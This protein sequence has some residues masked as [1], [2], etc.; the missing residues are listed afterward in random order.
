LKRNPPI[1][2]RLTGAIPWV[3]RVVQKHGMTVNKANIIP[4]LRYRDATK[5]IEWLCDAFGFEQQVVVPGP[6]GTIAHAQLTL[7]NGM[8]MLGSVTP[9]DYGKLVKQPDETGGAV[10]QSTYV[11]I[12][13]ADA[14]YK[15]AKAAGAEILIDIKNEDYGGRGYTCRDPEGHIWNFG[16]YDPWA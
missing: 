1:A 16:T 8:I 15:K 5:A 11:I 3:E 2:D 13:D 9:S 14:H 4:A 12:P 10:T 7:G 6:N